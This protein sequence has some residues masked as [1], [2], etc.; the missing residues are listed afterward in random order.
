MIQSL[1]QAVTEPRVPTGAK[2]S[3]L[4]GEGADL[5][6]V[7]ANELEGQDFANEL[8]ASL[9]DHTEVQP[10]QISAEELLRPSSSIQ[11]LPQVVPE[12]AG[13]KVFDP[14]LTK[15]VEKL[16]D[17]S[18]QVEIPAMT[19]AQVLELANSDAKGEFSQAVLKT[20]QVNQL[21]GRA[22]AIDFAKS[23][24]D[25]QLMNMEDFV[26]QKNLSLK[27][28]LQTNA[29]SMGPQKGK[30]PI[31]TDLKSTEVITDISKLEGGQAKSVN[32]QQ[33][34][35]DMLKEQGSPKETDVQ[36]VG[37]VFDMNQVKSS[38]ANQVM[39][40]ITDYVVQAK[41]AKE[42]T[43]NMRLKH[44][45]L[46]LIDITVKKGVANDIAINIGAH[47]NDGKNFFNLNSKEL[48][49]HLS[50]AGISVS[51]IKVETPSQTA[52]SDFD[53]NNQNSS[54]GEQGRNFGSEQN[55]RRHDADR[56]RDLWALLNDKEAA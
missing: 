26:A 28:N 25:P 2:S 51:D 29:Y 15:R 39:A 43:V 24:V 49:T 37:K 10:V 47:S 23:E 44:D 20:P 34:I 33:F 38:D 17:P 45:E 36:H 55:Q 27:K 21:Q 54:R 56:R 46:G 32:S 22:P 42:P 53:M 31:E 16:I 30:L 40:Q 13:P 50:N 9:A 11:N 14:S 1:K 3:A 7:L 48:F 41:A 5:L 12:T 52:K 35:L 6:S 4:E 8:A 18:A 19:D